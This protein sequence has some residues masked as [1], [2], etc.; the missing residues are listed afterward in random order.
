M[1][2]NAHSGPIIDAVHVGGFCRLKSDVGFVQPRGFE[3]K[4][5]YIAQ[6]GANY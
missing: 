3:E 6:N 2:K 1:P 4:V 5:V